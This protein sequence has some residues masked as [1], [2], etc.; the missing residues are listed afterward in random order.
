MAEEVDPLGRPRRRAAGFH[1]FTFDFDTGAWQQRFPNVSPPGVCCIDGANTFDV[2]NRRFVRFPGASLGHGYQWSRGVKLKAS[3][4]W[5]YDPAANHWTNMRPAPYRPFLANEGLGSLNATATYDPVHELSLSFGGQA[6][7]GGTNNLFAYDA[8]ANRLYRLKAA[9]AP[10]PRDGMGLAYDAKNDC[11]VLFGSQYG[12]DEKTWIYRY[13]SEKWESHDLDPHPPGRKDKLTYSTIPKMAY[14]AA[15]GIVLCVTWDTT[16]NEHQT[17]AFDAAKLAWTK[18]SPKVEADPSMSRSRNLDYIAKHNVF[19]LETSSKAGKGKEPEIWTYRYRQ[20][21]KK[22]ATPY[23][24]GVTTQENAATLSW[25][26]VS[27]GG[28]FK[29]FHVFRA[30]A[31][32]TWKAKFEKIATHSGFNFDGGHPI[33]ITDKGLEAGKVYFYQVKAIA[34]DGSVIASSFRGRTQPPVDVEPV[35]SVLA[36]DKIKVTWQPSRGQ[37][38]IF[39]PGGDDIA[40]YNVYRGLVTMRA[41][42]TGEQTAWRDNDP[43]YAEPMPVEV[44]EIADIRKLNDKLLTGTSFTDSDVNLLKKDAGPSE[45]KH[46]VYAYIV[47]S[48]NRLGTESGPSPYALTIPSAPQF[49]FNRE[50][51]DMAQLKWAPAREENIAG[52]HVY[53][54]GKGVWQIVRVTD[55]PVKGT[56]FE[57]QGGKNTTRYW[58]TAVDALGQ[59]GEPSSPVWHQR[60]YK[61]YFEGEWHQ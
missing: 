12:N 46:Q 5:L 21:T 55:Q 18:M 32:E 57:H 8:Y 51:G 50:K 7:S 28:E 14:D 36:A 20:A 44:R 58:I 2:A 1:L 49:V 41:V 56:T 4:V 60:S 24:L 25:Y 26:P 34:R 19:V 52:F 35:V 6:S 30:R 54:L 42:K 59:E 43:D 27:I 33:R 17:W 29:E 53:K 38:P 10:S 23:G 13:K 11:L 3:N 9:N 16:T 39:V 31:D 40:G 48:V 37:V 22:P 15:N 47:K 61:G 45:Y